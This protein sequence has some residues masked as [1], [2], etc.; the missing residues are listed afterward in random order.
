MPR[1]KV[2]KK[3]EVYFPDAIEYQTTTNEH[4]NFSSEHVPDKQYYSKQYAKAKNMQADLDIWKRSS[5]TYGGGQ[6]KQ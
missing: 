2:N 4:G 3:V 1:R 6:G 5:D